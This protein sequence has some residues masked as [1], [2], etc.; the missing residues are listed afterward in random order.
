MGPSCD[1]VTL[2]SHLGEKSSLSAEQATA[3]PGPFSACMGIEYPPST[4]TSAVWWPETR[5]V[6]HA[7]QAAPAG[8]TTSPVSRRGCTRGQ[9]HKL[10]CVTEARRELS[11]ESRRR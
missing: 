7:T 10:V 4:P 6:S 11:W 5:P 2:H 1:R 9:L 8:G 3:L